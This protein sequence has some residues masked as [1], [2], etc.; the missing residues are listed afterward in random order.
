MYS[1]AEV[2]KLGQFHDRHSQL[3]SKTL[4]FPTDRNLEAGNS[5]FLCRMGILLL[6][7]L[8]RFR[9][10][11]LLFGNFEVTEWQTKKHNIYFVRKEIP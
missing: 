7:I 9:H 1:A 5:T 2:S 10:G 8:R 3:F 6:G 4:H 11:S